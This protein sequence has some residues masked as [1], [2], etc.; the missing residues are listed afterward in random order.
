MDAK[1]NCVISMPQISADKKFFPVSPQTVRPWYSQL[2]ITELILFL[3]FKPIIGVLWATI[4]QK[5]QVS[6]IL[7]SP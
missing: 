6:G 7:S 2:I 3:T 1:G 5:Q 4:A